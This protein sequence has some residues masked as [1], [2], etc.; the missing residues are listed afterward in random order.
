MNKEKNDCRTLQFNY[1]TN[2]NFKSTYLDFERNRCDKYNNLIFLKRMQI[3][4]EENLCRWQKLLLC[5]SLEWFFNTL[6]I[7]FGREL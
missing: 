5:C 1:C 4:E 7:A 2:Y 6:L 3:E